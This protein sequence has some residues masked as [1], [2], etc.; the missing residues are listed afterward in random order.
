MS[1]VQMLLAARFVSPIRFATGVIPW[2]GVQLESARLVTPTET[3]CL[4]GVLPGIDKLCLKVHPVNDL[5]VFHQHYNLF[6][7]L[8][9]ARARVC[10]CVC[11]RER[12]RESVCVCLCVLCVCVC[13]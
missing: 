3:I 10:V 6:H 4:K 5:L 9:C 2:Q 11:V 7:F 13:V 8:L 12:E 1:S